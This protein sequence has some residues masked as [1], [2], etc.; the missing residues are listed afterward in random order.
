MPDYVVLI[1]T[2][3]GMAM[4]GL[5]G[6]VI[7][8]TIA[9]LF[10]ASW[11]LL[12]SSEESQ[13]APPAPP[14]THSVPVT[15]TMPTPV[16]T[17]VIMVPSVVTTTTRAARRGGHADPRGTGRHSGDHGAADGGAAPAMHGLTTGVV[18]GAMLPPVLGMPRRYVHVNRRTLN[19]HLGTMD[20][21]RLGIDQCRGRCIANLDAAINARNDLPIH[22]R[23]HVG[24]CTH[25]ARSQQQRD[26][27]ANDGPCAAEKTHDLLQ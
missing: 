6:F 13:Q 16:A 5:T 24:L 15:T 20:D 2:L 12:A 19:R 17:V 1:S 23:I 7:G 8:P 3:G 26:R 21:H 27:Y 18:A 22:G 25:A 10:M 11:D 4:F 14:E 9:A